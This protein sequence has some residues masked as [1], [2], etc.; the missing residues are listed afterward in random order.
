MKF[1]IIATL[2]L[3]MI[4]IAIGKKQLAQ[5]TDLRENLENTSITQSATASSRLRVA[6]SRTF[7]HS[8][9]G[10]TKNITSIYSGNESEVRE[11]RTK[12]ESEFKDFLVGLSPNELEG[13]FQNMRDEPSLKI[14]SKARIAC[15]CLRLIADK[16]PERALELALESLEWEGFEDTGKIW[17]A[18]SIALEHIAREDP[19]AAWAW[20]TTHANTPSE[21]VFSS[22]DRDK[23]ANLL[24][25]EAGK[26]DFALAFQALKDT[27]VANQDITS[28][29]L[30]R[31]LNLE[32]GPEF[33]KA[34]RSSELPDHHI[35]SAFESLA[36]KDLSPDYRDTL[37]LLTD[38]KLTQSEMN[39]FVEG[40]RRRGGTSPQDP[41]W[42]D[43]II[44]QSGGKDSLSSYQK[45]IIRNLQQSYTSFDYVAAGDWINAKPKGVIRDYLAL[46]YA[47]DLSY[48][49][50]ATA[51]EWART[52]PEDTEVTT[53]IEKL[54]KKLN[55][56]PLNHSHH[57]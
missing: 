10:I 28:S 18:T 8:I 45:R 5:L 49:E 43:W 26:R 29:S 4:T 19:Q 32:R 40:L 23:I 27:P 21:K 16:N 6:R 50:P 2:A 33:I 20:F 13:V 48:E 1:S 22:R 17:S 42:L 11:D 54:T 44:S 38:S 9:T 31:S 52:L 25:H 46:R 7:D 36:L 51:L 56:Q 41:H 37:Q 57:Q 53:L 30:A 12:A 39:S 55:P 14:S 15:Y 35:A 24:L 47:Y 34:A 3:L